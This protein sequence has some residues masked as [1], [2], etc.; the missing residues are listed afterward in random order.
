MLLGLIAQYRAAHNVPDVYRKVRGRSLHYF[1]IDGHQVEEH[2]E[3]VRKAIEE[4]GIN[5]MLEVKLNG[6][7]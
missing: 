1:V 4:Q 6:I 7:D 3:A 5:H 2:L